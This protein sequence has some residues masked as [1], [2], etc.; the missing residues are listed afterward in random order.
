MPLS[1]PEKGPLSTSTRRLV[2]INF[3]QQLGFQ[4]TYFVGI[5]GCATYILGAGALEISILVF[6]LNVFLVVGTFCAG[7]V[8][9]AIGPRSPRSPT[10]GDSSRSSPLHHWSTKVDFLVNER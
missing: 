6:C 7:V 10:S 1:M 2:A 8:I 4:S 3:L 5:I 9:D